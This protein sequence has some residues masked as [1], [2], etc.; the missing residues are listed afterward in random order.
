[1]PVFLRECLIRAASCSRGICLTL[2]HHII[3]STIPQGPSQPRQP[4]SCHHKMWPPRV[5]ATATCQ[6]TRLWTGLAWSQALTTC[7]NAVC[8]QGSLF[9]GY[10][11]SVASYCF[12]HVSGFPCKNILEPKYH[13][14]NQF[15]LRRFLFVI[16][17]Y[18][19]NGF[20][21]AI[22]YHAGAGGIEADRQIVSNP[23]LFQQ[24]W[25]ALLSAIQSL[26][27]YQTNL[28]GMK[29]WAPSPDS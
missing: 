19:A 23:A 26:P 1:M 2:L 17:F 8:D 22:D 3:T 18:I 15:L 20:Y 16:Q 27:T 10:Y 9:C 12:V 21:V 28:K 5:C 6:W 25:L 4:Q 7:I 14:R 13:C 29:C 24:N 11:Q